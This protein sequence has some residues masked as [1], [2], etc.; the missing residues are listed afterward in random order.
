[1]VKRIVL[2]GS[3]SFA[4]PTFI[5]IFK[6]PKYEI[7]GLY[8]QPDKKKGRGQKICQTACKKFAL[9]KNIPVF[10]PKSLNNDFVFE[11]FKN[12]KPDLVLVAAYGKIIPE[13]ILK[14]PPFSTFNI[15]SSLLPELRGAAPINWAIVRGYEKTGITIFKIEKKLDSGDIVF[16]KEVEI[17]K[18]ETAKDL[19]DKLAQI[20]GSIICKVLDDIFSKRVPFKPQDESKVTFAPL[21]KKSDGK[22]DFS[23][24]GLQ[25][26]NLIRGFYPWP[27]TYAF[28]NKK[29]LKFIEALI[30]PL[31][32]KYEHLTNGTL[33]DIEKGLL[34]LSDSVLKLKRVQLEGKKEMNWEIFKCGLK[35]N[36][37]LIILK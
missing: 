25:I 16:Q 2:M 24:S 17:K 7:V 4:I 32:S 5:E 26:F 18:D 33:F 8:C 6:N 22:I 3:P 12:L 29:I 28:M 27:G 30:L 1:V 36:D 31:E 19:H 9:E 14:V 13:R 21:I 15:H 34:K 35:N 10:E 37:D 23:L 11:E 20:S